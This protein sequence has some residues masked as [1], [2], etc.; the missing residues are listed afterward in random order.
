MWLVQRGSPE[1]KPRGRAGTESEEDQR[2]GAHAEADSPRWARLGGWRTRLY[3]NSLAL[4]MGLIFLA[5]WAIQSVAGWKTFNSSRIDHDQATIAWTGYLVEPEFWESTFQ[6]WQ[7]EFLA[8]GSMAVLSVYLRQRGSP[9]SKPVGASH[10]A[11]G[12]EG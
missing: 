11:T 3:S 1:S 2:I 8:V 9:E 10:G 4:V 6:N 7:S 12:T 5:S